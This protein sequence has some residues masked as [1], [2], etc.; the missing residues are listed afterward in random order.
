VSP[1]FQFIGSPLHVSFSQLSAHTPVSYSHIIGYFLYEVCPL[2]I[3]SVET[4]LLKGFIIV[5]SR[6]A[7]YSATDHH[8]T[9]SFPTLPDRLFTE[10]TPSQSGQST[11]LFHRRSPSTHLKSAGILPHADPFPVL[12]N[13]GCCRAVH[14]FPQYIHSN[15]MINNPNY[16]PDRIQFSDLFI[17]TAQYSHFSASTKYEISFCALLTSFE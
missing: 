1:N 17:K 8:R 14:S 11:S 2:L 12:E 6:V 4:T 5:K 13:V 16:I 15:I 3:A 9:T 7:L 10:Y